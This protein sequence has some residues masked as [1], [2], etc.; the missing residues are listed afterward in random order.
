MSKHVWR[1]DSAGQVQAL[2]ALADG[3]TRPLTPAEEKENDEDLQAALQQFSQ[4]LREMELAILTDPNWRPPK[5]TSEAV[6]FWAWIEGKCPH[7]APSAMELHIAGLIEY[8]QRFG[9]PPTTTAATGKPL[10][11]NARM[12]A[13]LADDAT[14]AAWTSRAWAEALGINKST[15]QRT[16]VWAAILEA[17]EARKI[18]RTTRYGRL[19]D[20]PFEETD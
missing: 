20:L 16:R 4:P 13:M 9:C 2:A 14:L 7:Y 12:A 11:A 19:K 15:V 1:Y 18:A 6:R 10:P 5:P 17:R 3:T 8:R